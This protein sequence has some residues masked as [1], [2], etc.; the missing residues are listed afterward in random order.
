MSIVPPAFEDVRKPPSRALRDDRSLRLPRV[1]S[2]SEAP[3]RCSILLSDYTPV[4]AG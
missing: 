2:S 1:D 3:E 4:L